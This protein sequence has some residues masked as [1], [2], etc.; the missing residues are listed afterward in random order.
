MELK[1]TSD[2]M[3]CLR[4]LCSGK[5]NKQIAA[6]IISST[7]TVQKRLT[8]VYKKLGV[9]S[10]YMAIV[11]AQQIGFVDANDESIFDKLYK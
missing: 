1:L 9:K 7:S 6:A 2:E 4:L 10:R 11:K 3:E 5:T 8:S